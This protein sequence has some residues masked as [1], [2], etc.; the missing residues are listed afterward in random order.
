MKL[1]QLVK[2]K[3]LRKKARRVWR[4]NATWTGNYSGR[5]LKGQKSRSGHSMKP[6]FEWGQTSIVQRLP[7]ARWFT[8]HPKLVPVWQIINLGKLH[9]DE[10][11]S[12]AMEISKVIL[13]ELWYIKN[14]KGLVK[15]LGDG[16]YAK[17]LTFVDID[18]FSV[19]AQAKIDKPGSSTWSK[20][21][22]YVKIV[23]TKK[24]SSSL[25]KLKPVKP[26][27][28]K[29]KKASITALSVEKTK[30]PVKLVS[31]KKA[32]VVDTKKPAPAKT[33]TNK[34]TGA[35]KKP[36]AAKKAPAKSS[37]IKAPAKKPAT[38]KSK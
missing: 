22:P 17:H 15:I 16:E 7:K 36:A 31:V 13:K 37:S 11:I 14:E 8:R 33:S 5:W 24:S 35:V 1:H 34:T 21:K 6:F 18:S 23:K 28:A 32:P 27:S 20:G 19:S 9:L 10:R 25:K 38:K 4:G 29:G 2:S 30:E 26:A 3:G 12:D